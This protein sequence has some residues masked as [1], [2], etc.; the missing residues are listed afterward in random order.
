MLDRLIISSELK[1]LYQLYKFIKL[2]HFLIFDILTFYVDNET[3]FSGFF[4]LNSIL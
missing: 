3:R 4:K 1:L 2:I